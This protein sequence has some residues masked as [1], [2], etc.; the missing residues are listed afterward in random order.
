M[1]S[2]YQREL[3]FRKDGPG[4]KICKLKKSKFWELQFFSIV[5]FK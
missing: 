2:W 4:D 3:E 5:T 1:I